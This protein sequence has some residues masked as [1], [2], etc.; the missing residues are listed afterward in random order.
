MNLNEAK[1]ILKTNG[2]NVL[3]ESEYDLP[4]Y[5]EFVKDTNLNDDVPYK[6]KDEYHAVFDTMI[7]LAKPILLKSYNIKPDMV[8][9]FFDYNGYQ[10]DDWFYE[11]IN[12][13]NMFKALANHIIKDDG[14]NS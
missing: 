6:Y 9:K 1:T 3:K 14:I 2:Y 13:T 5:D 11:N 12:W 8:E 10:I 7:T 4:D